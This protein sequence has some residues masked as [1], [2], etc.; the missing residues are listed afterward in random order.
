[1]DTEKL[2]SI[3]QTHIKD[4][5]YDKV[6]PIVNEITSSADDI[7]T[8]L[9]CASLLKVVDD[10]EGCQKLLD[11]VAGKAY[12][13]KNRMSVAVSLRSLGRPDD[14][15]DLIKDEEDTDDVLYEKAASLLLMDEGGEALSN[16]R[17]I[18]EMTAVRSF[19]LSEILCS[20]GEF[21]E[22]YDVSVQLV[23]DE[24]SSYRSLVNLC[25]TLILMGK[26][27]E[28]VKTAKQHLKEGKDADSFALN[29]Y[30]MRINGKIPAA[31]N[32]AH[33]ALSADYKHKGAQ[34]TMAYC[35]IE[36]GRFIEAKIMAGAINENDPG[37][38]AAIRILDAC[39]QASR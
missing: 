21:K 7:G 3:I 30:V 34:E 11:R 6:R 33:R 1:M 39:R 2:F 32:Y 15:Y 36:K 8:L 9:K 19:L 38:V 16:M 18:K 20:V 37:S 4:N 10:E 13:E 25:S 27:K 29:A 23:N 28:A 26:N 22:A 35:L 17:K 24:D 31:A 14:A 12:D 5:E